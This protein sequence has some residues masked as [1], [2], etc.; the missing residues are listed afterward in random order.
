MLMFFFSTGIAA[1]S[2]T[3]ST[4]VIKYFM[5]NSIRFQ[6]AKDPVEGNP[7]KMLRKIFFYIGLAECFLF[8]VKNG[9]NLCTLPCK[10]QARL[11][12]Y[13]LYLATVHNLKCLNAQ[14]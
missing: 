9:Q 5:K 12:Q 3:G 10:P 11:L 8:I 14:M 2:K 13:L 6:G 4:A 7:V 1:K